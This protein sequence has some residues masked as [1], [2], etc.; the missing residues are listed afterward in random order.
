M[1][2]LYYIFYQTCVLLY[3]CVYIMEHDLVAMLNTAHFH[4]NY[5]IITNIDPQSH[6]RDTVNIC[7][8]CYCPVQVKE[9][10][11]FSKFLCIHVVRA[12]KSYNNAISSTLV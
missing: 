12:Q 1:W 11:I 2:I 3:T 10:Q 4:A 6:K 9:I 7:N 8:S 5:F